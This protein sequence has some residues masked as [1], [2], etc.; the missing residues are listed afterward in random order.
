[1]VLLNGVRERDLDVLLA[2]HLTAS[3]NFRDFAL[4]CL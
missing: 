1:M 3:E 4:R 2:A